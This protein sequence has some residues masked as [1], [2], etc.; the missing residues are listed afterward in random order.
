[1]SNGT[2]RGA[3]AYYY[4]ISTKG[5]S[6][7][8]NILDQVVAVDGCYKFRGIKA[9]TTLADYKN[10]SAPATLL[11][12]AVHDNKDDAEWISNK[13]DDITNAIA[14]SIDAYA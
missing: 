1:M 2:A 14:N 10:I 11:E 5:K 12:V 13:M 6:F 4:S 3:G 8:Q 7:A 9:T